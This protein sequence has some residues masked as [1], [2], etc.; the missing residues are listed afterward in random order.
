M[1]RAAAAGAPAAPRDSRAALF[2]PGTE[3]KLS[4][5]GRVTVRPWSIAVLVT[6]SQRLPER[7]S[8]MMAGASSTAKAIT[9]LPEAVD[10]LR[11]LAALTLGIPEAQ[12]DAEWTAED[13][14][15]VGGAVFD[16]CITP[17]AEKLLGLA[18]RVLRT[19]APAATR[20]A[21]LAGPSPLPPST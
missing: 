12:I 6:V 20:K 14:L 11:Y 7:L 3:V 13:L 18:Q 4:G 21:T 17:I 19:A 8:A 10:E 1:P 16:T 2:P 15:D 9:L 5:G